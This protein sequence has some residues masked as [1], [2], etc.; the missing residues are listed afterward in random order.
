MAN[1]KNALV[2]GSTS[3]I[4]LGIAKA[5]AQAGYNVMLNGLVRND[6]E[7]NAAEKIAQ[8][9]ASQY[10]VKTLFNPANM[11]K[12]EEIRAMVAQAEQTWG[13]VDVLVNNAGIQFVSPIEDFPEDK[14]DAIIAIN[15][16][17]AFHTSKA[18]WKGMK[19]RGWGR[20]I[21][22]TSAHALQAS[23]FKSAYVASKHGVTGLTKTLAL[24]GATCGITCNAICPGYVLTPLVEGQIP[25]QM[26]AHNMTREEVIQKVML[27]KHAIKDFVTVEQ[28]G[29][30]VVFLASDAAK[31][32]TGASIPIDGGWSAQ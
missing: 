2:T 16:T 32:I 25:D 30:L 18:V 20:I 3:G 9:I 22:I 8:E 26:K 27:Y 1:G 12:P 4:G 5:L 29:A 11:M 28:I 31:L 6:D 21:N 19:A 10:S 24:E 7:R 15:L 14:W 23:E 17:A 13:S